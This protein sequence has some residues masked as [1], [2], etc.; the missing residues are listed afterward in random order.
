MFYTSEIFIIEKKHIRH[1]FPWKLINQTQTFAP[2]LTRSWTLNEITKNWLKYQKPWDIEIFKRVLHIINNKSVLHS[3]SFIYFD[4]GSLLISVES[5]EHRLWNISSGKS[6]SF[7][8][9][10]KLPNLL[11][12]IILWGTNVFWGNFLS[13]TFWYYGLR[14]F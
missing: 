10:E 5:C 9:V 4:N 8:P 7:V 1:R 13:D 11:I 2:H 3:S 12:P 6:L 14:L